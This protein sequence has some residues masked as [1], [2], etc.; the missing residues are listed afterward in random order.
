MNQQGCSLGRRAVL[1]AP[2]GAQSNARGCRRFITLSFRSR[3]ARGAASLKVW[4]KVR[5]WR[6][7]LLLGLV[8]PPPL[9]GGGPGRVHPCF[10]PSA[11]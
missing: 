5:R 11:R 10:A 2:H 4:E 1:P 3:L 7:F 9:V 8:V 6:E